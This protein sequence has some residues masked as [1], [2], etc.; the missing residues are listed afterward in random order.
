MGRVRKPPLSDINRELMDTLIGKHVGYTKDDASKRIGMV[1]Y[2]AVAEPSVCL[3]TF[4]DTVCDSA[5]HF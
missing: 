5:K 3:V 1:I 4:E 2:Q